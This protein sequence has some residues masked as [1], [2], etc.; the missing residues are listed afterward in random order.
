MLEGA[1]AAP[2]ILV[3][4]R[5]GADV[6]VIG[7]HLEFETAPFAGI[8]E[9]R[10]PDPAGHVGEAEPDAADFGEVV[11]KA[12]VL[13]DAVHLVDDIADGDGAPAGGPVIEMNAAGHVGGV[14]ADRQ[15]RSRQVNRHPVGRRGIALPQADLPVVPVDCGNL[16]DSDAPFGLL[17]GFG[18]DQ[19]DVA[20]GVG[21]RDVQLDLGPGGDV[22]VEAA[23]G[24]PAEAGV[25]DA[26]VDMEQLAPVAVV[27][28]QQRPRDDAVDHHLVL[29]AA[30]EGIVGGPAFANRDNI[31]KGE[32]RR[33]EH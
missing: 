12:V 22:L 27:G 21:K 23:L 20:G 14:V 24:D 31:D 17:D 19:V 6:G 15:V 33:R 13:V 4:G 25:F 30:A 9:T 3:V 8:P 11:A 28:V 2:Q 10:V 1:G 5:P 32:H 7:P 18:A 29:V 16:L 26:A